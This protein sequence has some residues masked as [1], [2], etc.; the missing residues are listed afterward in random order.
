MIPKLSGS[1]LGRKLD[2]GSKHVDKV[3]PSLL[4]ASSK[5]VMVA[6]P[7]KSSVK[8]LHQ[9]ELVLVSELPM[10]LLGEDSRGSGDAVTD[11]AGMDSTIAT[12]GGS[13]PC[14]EQLSRSVLKVRES[15]D[16]AAH[17]SQSPPVAPLVAGTSQFK[18]KL[19]RIFLLRW[20]YLPS[21]MLCW[22][23]S[24]GEMLG[25]FLMSLLTEIV[26]SWICFWR[27]SLLHC[28]AV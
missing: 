21:L 23:W 25:N 20:F 3:Y 28:F 8:L 27:R 6:S 12:F 10:T 17:R 7:S 1:A 18:L 5:P 22:I 14:V 2:V 26:W 24:K 11:G 9:P 19:C 4:L 16:S 13:K 15:V